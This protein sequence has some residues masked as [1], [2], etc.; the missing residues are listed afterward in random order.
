[1]AAE[2]GSARHDG[3][4]V[5]DGHN[6]LPFAL[7]ER[8]GVEGAAIDLDVEVEGVQTDLPRLRGV[9]GAQFWSVFVPASLAGPPAVAATL[10]QI[11]LVR[12]LVAAHPADLRLCGTAAEVEAAVAD[13]RIASL[14]GV[15]GG[16]CIDESLGVLRSLH[17][18]GARYMTLTHNDNVPWAD[19]ATDEPVLHGLSPF[20]REVVRELERLGMFVDLSHVSDAVMADALDVATAPVIFSHSSARALCDSPRNVPDPVLGE[21]AGNGGVCMVAYV[22]PFV[23]QEVA[24]WYLDV[25]DEVDARGG[26]R[27]DYGTVLAVVE[28]RRRTDPPPPCTAEDVADHVEHV[29]AV[30]GIEH[31]GLGS[32]YDGAPSMPVDM[33]DVAGHARL[34]EV[35]R[36]RGWSEDEL[37][38]LAHGNVLRAMRDV[39]AVAAG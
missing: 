12:R 17:T 1:M 33:G 18:L 7:R 25:L 5:F 31:V 21:L 9:V 20:G 39:E 10:E 26:D 24:D 35:L 3:P 37:V 13:G 4:W 19:S 29:R 6:D 23:K 32:D 34:L 27:R 15:E 22:A 28:E 30:A 14:I 8:H 2:Q 38:A 36:S 16:H 11:D